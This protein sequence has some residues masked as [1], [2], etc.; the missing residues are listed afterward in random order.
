MFSHFLFSPLV[1]SLPKAKKIAYIAVVTAITIVAN[2]F[3]ELKFLGVQ[4]SLTIF[5]S[6]LAGIILG[7]LPAFVACFLGDLFGFLLHP[8]GEYSPFIGISTGLM[9]VFG[10]LIVALPA[11]FKGGLFVKIALVCVLI[12]CVCTAGITTVYLNAVW[13]KS[14]T[15]GECLVARLFAEGQ[16]WNSVG[17]YALLFAVVP[18]LTKIQPLGVKFQ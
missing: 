2:T 13:Y 5:V 11:A 10:A 12:F 6:V 1:L 15:Y 7:A 18:T 9:A 16:I 17:N 8:M 3:F 14:L 4:F